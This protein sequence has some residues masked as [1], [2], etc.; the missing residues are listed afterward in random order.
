M[1]NIKSMAIVAGATLAA[2]AFAQSKAPYKYTVLPNYDAATKTYLGLPVTITNNAWLL[3]QAQHGTA[4]G[5]GIIEST[6]TTHFFS[7]A[8][9]GDYIT[10]MNTHH[11]VTGD[12]PSGAFLVVYQQPIFYPAP[13]TSDFY[14]GISDYG[15]VGYK[16]NQSLVFHDYAATYGSVPG[17]YETM[18]RGVSNN[19]LL[20]GTY[21]DGE[22]QGWSYDTE[23][24]NVIYPGSSLTVALG[25]NNSANMVG[26]YGTGNKTGLT[27]GGWVC[28]KG[29]FYNV[30]VPAPAA[31]IAITGDGDH[32]ADDYAYLNDYV[33]DPT[34][35]NDH[36]AFVGS[37][38][39][40]Y[41]TKHGQ[42]TTTTWNFVASPLAP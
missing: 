18:A 27:Q 7:Y 29:T 23:Y 22:T 42:C 3:R 39:A 38:I 26:T 25:I 19:G 5:F 4:Q 13:G 10:S 15:Y 40:H 33:V 37:V 36:D 8:A 34:S 14:W 20:C 2:C 30:A 1:F 31:K 16:G 41:Y 35:I 6:G 11:T 9:P 17:T 28:L 12:G 32:D 24:H 21:W